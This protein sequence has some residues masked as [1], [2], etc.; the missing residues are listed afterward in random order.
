MTSDYS[1]KDRDKKEKKRE[2]ERAKFL[3]L[4]SVLG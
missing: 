4:F 1:L 3:I 2:R